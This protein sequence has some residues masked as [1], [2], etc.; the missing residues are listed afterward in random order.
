MQN[1]CALSLIL[2]GLASVYTALIQKTRLVAWQSNWHEKPQ[3]FKNS[4]SCFLV[5]FVESMYFWSIWN[6]SI[7]AVILE[8]DFRYVYASDQVVLSLKLPNSLVYYEFIGVRFSEILKTSSLHVSWIHFTSKARIQTSVAPWGCPSASTTCD[9]SWGDSWVAA[10]TFCFDDCVR[11]P[12][13]SN[14]L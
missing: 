8:S 4:G 3:D 1:L 9:F 14:I 11:S 10:S 13:N 2:N 5:E 12:Y 7:L 6:S